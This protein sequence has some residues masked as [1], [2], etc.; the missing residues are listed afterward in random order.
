MCGPGTG[1]APFR[2]FLQERKATNA[3]G[4]AWL[5]FGETS[6]A[7]CY[8]YREEFEAYLADGT[9]NRMDCAWSRDQAEKIYVQHKMLENSAGLWKW[10][11]EG[12]I[13]YVCGDASRM[14]LD[15]DRA[16]HQIVGKEGGK[17]PEEA[18]AYMEELKKAKRYRRD[19]Y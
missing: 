2:A 15:V 14:A 12:A 11:E 1:V 7:T 3:K 19:V 10:L 5:F 6:E 13:F 8:F 9:L 18:V 4:K 17:S 16:L